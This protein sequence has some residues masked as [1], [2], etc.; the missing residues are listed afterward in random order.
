MDAVERLQDAV[1]AQL[2]P[3]TAWKL[4]ATIPAVRQNL[5]LP[6]AFFGAL[7]ARRVFAAGATLGAMVARQR[8]VEC[9]YGF[10]LARDVTRAD[11]DLDADGLAELI[12]SVHPAI[13]IPGT[14]FASLGQY[15]GMA[16]AAD[17]GAAGALVIGPGQPLHN[18][19]RL[20]SARIRLLIDGVETATGDATVIEGGA[21]GPIRA[22]IRNTLS[23]NHHLKAGQI[24]V[25]GS[26]TGYIV[27]PPQ[28]SVTAE[29]AALDASVSLRFDAAIH[30]AV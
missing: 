19:T 6:R 24:I 3:I 2:G 21:F 23:R 5:G 26:C 18:P 28:S 16:L 20:D 9:E 17:F 27:A 25:T 29:F 8:G 11:L 10:R 12:E 15:G 13:E 14:R 7:P 30:D 1:I 22:F 4:G